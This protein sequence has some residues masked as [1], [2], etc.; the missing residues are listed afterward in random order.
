MQ[1]VFGAQQAGCLP[2]TPASRADQLLQHMRATLFSV[3]SWCALHTSHL[4]GGSV[5][6]VHQ[7]AG[8]ALS[9]AMTL[10][11]Q[12]A[13]AAGDPF[14]HEVVYSTLIDVGASRQLL[15]LDSRSAHLESFL[16][17]AG[18]LEGT[19]PGVPLPPLGPDQAGHVL[20]TPGSL[21]WCRKRAAK[22]S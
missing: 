21:A 16:R 18:G 6:H 22:Q 13:A 3:S 10:R 11:P 9:S 8:S 4:S 20:M 17:R 2:P 14:F 5:V 19:T 12:A 15:G 7:A 1:T